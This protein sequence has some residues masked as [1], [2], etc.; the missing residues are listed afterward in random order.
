MGS[1][2]ITIAAGFQFARAIDA[3]PKALAI[4]FLAVKEEGIVAR[5]IGINLQPAG[6]GAGCVAYWETVVT[7]NN[8]I[9]PALFKCFNKSILCRNRLY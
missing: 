8:V 2:A 7:D 6:H 9:T 4:S 5:G 1:I 3:Q